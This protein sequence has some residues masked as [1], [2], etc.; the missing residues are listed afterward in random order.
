METKRTTEIFIETNRRIVIRQPD[1]AAQIICP[2]CAEPM[3]TAERTAVVFGISR[4]TVYQIVENTA[5]H[6]VETEAGILQ[7]CPNSFG[8]FLTNHK[9]NF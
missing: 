6:F 9:L 8:E 7:V 3:L 2:D 5:A 4:R 1:S